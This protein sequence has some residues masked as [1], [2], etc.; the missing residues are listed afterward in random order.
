VPVLEVWLVGF[1]L[2]SFGRIVVYNY[3]SGRYSPFSSISRI[4]FRYWCS[5]CDGD[6]L[7]VMVSCGFRGESAECRDSGS[8]SEGAMSK[9]LVELLLLCVKSGGASIG[10]RRVTWNPT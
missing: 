2:E 7:V 5:S 1:K 8:M 10:G 4:R 9:G 6:I 3:L